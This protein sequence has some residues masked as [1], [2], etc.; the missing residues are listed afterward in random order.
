MK[1]PNSAGEPEKISAPRSVKRDLN[2]VSASPSLMA[3]LRF[4]MMY[5]GVPFGAQMPC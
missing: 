3:L 1:R 4:P 2:F 5:S